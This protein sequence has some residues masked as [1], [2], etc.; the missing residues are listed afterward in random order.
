MTT[1]Q[2][3][4]L[5]ALACVAAYSYLPAIQWPA[6]TPTG[7]KP[8][9]LSQIKDVVAIRDSY[10]SSEITKACNT[11]LSVLLKVQ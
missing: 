6:K 3:L 5:V 1:I 2:I 7:K 4:S 11:L 10:D 8:D 9:I